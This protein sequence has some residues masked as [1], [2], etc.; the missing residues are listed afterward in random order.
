MQAA[1]A[2]LARFRA[3]QAPAPTFQPPTGM[4]AVPQFAPQPVTQSGMAQPPQQAPQP[5]APDFNS[6]EVQKQWREKIA[7]N[8]VTGLRE[9]VSL[10]IQSEGAPLLQQFQQ[11]ILGQL[12]PIQQT[13]AGQQLQSYAASRASDPSWQQV[14]PTFQQLAREAISRGYQPTPEVLSV[15][16]TIAR[17]QAGVPYYAPQPAAAAP[18]TERPGSGGAGFGAAQTPELTPQQR[19]VARQFG[20]TEQEY[21]A[22]LAS[23]RRA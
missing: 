11:Q 16:E 15:V 3:A 7:N 18:F 21:A 5:T 9:F 23:F 12:A 19:G 8:P 20:M 1:E 14:Q 17:Q 6:Q 4:Q 2:E 22:S 10:L 13:F